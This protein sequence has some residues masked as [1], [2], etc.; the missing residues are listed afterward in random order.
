VAV[1]SGVRVGVSVGVGCGV[2]VGAGVLVA[3][4]VSLGGAVVEGCGV[5]GISA[6]PWLQAARIAKQTTTPARRRKS[7]RLIQGR[8]FFFE[9]V[10]M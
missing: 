4:E 9:P 8:S 10:S 3:G 2:S 7:R 6:S 5:R 1:G